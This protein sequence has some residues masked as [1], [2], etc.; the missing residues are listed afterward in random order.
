MKMGIIFIFHNNEED[1]D[2][3]IFIESLQ[4]QRELE[5]CLVNNDSRDNTYDILQEIKEACKNVSLVN[6]KKFKSD[7]SAIR[8]G[9][10]FMF[11]NFN[12]CHMGYVNTFEFSKKYLTINDLIKKICNSQEE[13]LKYHI[14]ILKQQ[15]VKQTMFQNIFSVIDYLEKLKVDTPSQS[16]LNR[17]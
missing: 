17:I 16:E 11:S 7:N 5:L 6:I 10:R 8:A 3:G 2:P 13:I 14:S 15:Q 1:I 4:P 12:I 9:A